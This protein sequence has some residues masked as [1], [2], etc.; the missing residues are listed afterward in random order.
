M[1]STFR[2]LMPAEQP[3]DIQDILLQ[4]LTLKDYNSYPYLLFSSNLKLFIKEV[5]KSNTIIH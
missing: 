2:I 5:L 3:A 1:E 4:F